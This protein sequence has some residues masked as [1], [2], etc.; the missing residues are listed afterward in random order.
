MIPVISI[1]SSRF[2]AVTST[3]LDVTALEAAHCAPYAQDD[4]HIWT[5]DGR[6]LMEAVGHRIA[7]RTRAQADDPEPFEAVIHRTALAAARAAQ[8]PHDEAVDITLNT[9][10]EH[11]RVTI[12]VGPT[13]ITGDLH[14]PDVWKAAAAHRLE[15]PTTTPATPI[16]DRSLIDRALTALNRDGGIRIR[17]TSHGLALTSDNGDTT[18]VLINGGTGRTTPRN[19]LIIHGEHVL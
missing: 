13:I 7:I 9:D 3:I 19:P 15:R 12:A 6:I 16:L 2:A 5:R 14:D 17:P 4:V 11:E 18:V 8:P 1:N 10:T